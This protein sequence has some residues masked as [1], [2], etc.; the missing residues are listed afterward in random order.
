MPGLKDKI[1][2]GWIIAVASLIILTTLLGI[3]FSFGIFFKSLEVE[4]LLSRGVTSVIFSS[5]MVLYGAFALIAGWALDRYGPKLV[6]ALMGLATGLSLILTS[7]TDS[8]WQIFLSYSLLLG[9]GTGGTVPV[10]MAVVSRWFDRKRGL[11]LGV[12]TAGSGMGTLVFSPFA[13]FL[14]TALE[15]RIAY[16]V[17]GLIGLFVVMSLALVLRGEPG[18]IGALPDGIQPDSTVQP[19]QSEVD[20]QLIGLSLRESLR[21]RSLWLLLGAWSLFSLSL[22]LVVTHVVPYATDAG[23]STLEASTI[24]SVMGG[25]HIMSRLLVGRVSDTIGRK[26]PGT[27]SALMVTGS[28]VWLIWS[29][30]L[31]MFYL[32]AGFFGFGWGG[33]G[34]INI[35][36]VSDCF[37]RRGL[38]VIIGALEVGFALGVAAGSALGGFTF[39]ITGNYILAFAIGAACVFTATFSL[40]FIRSEAPRDK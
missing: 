34:V 12:A 28:L 31:W 22:S 37:G 25:F 23:I 16:L 20:L 9:I 13:A 2:Y 14:I 36:L 30:D 17:L 8:L 32:F 10:L 38:G 29:R 11:A 35:A 18:E 5:Y 7:Q 24:L 40:A 4:F 33:F 6:V 19:I 1:F 3:R 15:W 26:I 27:I 21:T 39:D